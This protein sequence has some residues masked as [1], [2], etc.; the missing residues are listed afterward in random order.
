MRRI[1]YKLG[2]DVNVNQTLHKHERGSIFLQI[3]IH[4]TMLMRK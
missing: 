2:H 3:Y 1:N 4:S